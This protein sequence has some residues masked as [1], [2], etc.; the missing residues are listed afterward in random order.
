MTGATDVLSFFLRVGSPQQKHEINS[1]FIQHID[2][3][4]SEQL[5][6]LALM[7]CCL[8]SLYRQYCIEQQ[9]TLTGPMLQ[10]PVPG[11]LDAEIPLQLF[12]DIQK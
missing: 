2:N 3:P 6:P 5:P 7:G 8:E 12:V 10:M 1:L 9:D 11:W 4:V